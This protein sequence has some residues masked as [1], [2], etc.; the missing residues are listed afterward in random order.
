[1]V[2]EIV[3]MSGFLSLAAAA[4]VISTGEALAML[5][6]TTLSDEAICDSTCED[7]FRTAVCCSRT[8]IGSVSSGSLERDMR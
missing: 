2:A 4:G 3:E 1:M 6:E 7:T 5:S 8:A